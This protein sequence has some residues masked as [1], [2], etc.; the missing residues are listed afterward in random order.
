MCGTET[1]AGEAI[2]TPCAESHIREEW[3][4]DREGYFRVRRKAELVAVLDDG[5]FHLTPG[6]EALD[7]R[8]SSLPET[9][10]GYR[11]ARQLMQEVFDEYCTGD[12]LKLPRHAYIA[13]SLDRIWRYEEIYPGDGD[14]SFYK[15]LASLYRAALKEFALPLVPA[16]FTEERKRM[17]EEKAD[18]WRRKGENHPADG[19]V[20]GSSHPSNERS[21]PVQKT[22]V[23]LLSDG[24]DIRLLRSKIRSMEEQIATLRRI[25]PAGNVIENDTDAI[26]MTAANR[27]S[28]LRG[29]IESIQKEI[30]ELRP[31]ERL[32]EGNPIDNSVTAESVKAAVT[33]EPET[34]D[35]NY[36]LMKKRLAVCILTGEYNDALDDA[37]K[38]IQQ[39]SGDEED[40]ISATLLSL[41]T[42]DLGR[43]KLIGELAATRGVRGQNCL[44][45]A[46]MAW[47][48]GK[49]GSA[50]QLADDEIERGGS[51]AAFLLKMNICRQYALSEKADELE[52]QRKSVGKLAE[53]A[54]LLSKMYLQLNMW[55]A[56]VQCLGILPEEDWTDAMWSVNGLAMEQKGDEDKAIEAYDRSLQLN[57]RNVTSV[58]RKSALLSGAG[59]K[60]EALELLNTAEALWPSVAR[61]RASIMESMGRSEEAL[62]LLKEAVR[63]D[64]GDM[65]IIR[66]GI[67][68]STS[69][70][71][72][73]DR[74][75]FTSILDGK[76]EA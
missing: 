9:R 32:P 43:L 8:I 52:E 42:R 76:E 60:T 27:I 59:R 40:F 55:G 4:S 75:Y 2:C 46:V 47:K 56:A 68:I 21:A 50:I 1:T 29:K 24:A 23:R 10:D 5:G 31:A 63:L 26:T 45:E 17:L 57:E 69:L 12:G 65:K 64:R 54:E 3:F 44:A 33:D 7:E 58:I 62:A 53:G 34:H 35:S 74:R 51:A 38:I 11:T 66:A 39:G 67:S 48:D 16:S 61:L 18:Y 37:I 73:K 14:E 72:R 49:W 20:K 36:D 41:R 25:V 71:R 15:S 19:E 6:G 30:V 22:S 70:G 28:E 13:R